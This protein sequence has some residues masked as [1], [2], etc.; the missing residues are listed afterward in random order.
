MTPST[1]FL[2]VARNAILFALYMP[3]RI[4]ASLAD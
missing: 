4:P 2:T 1:A 3:C